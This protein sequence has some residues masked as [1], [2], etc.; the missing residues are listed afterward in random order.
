MAR[1]LNKSLDNY[2][3]HL[4][5]TMTGSTSTYD[6]YNR[7]ISRFI[8]FLI[9]NEVFDFNDVSKEL[10]MDYLTKLKSGIIGGQKLSNSSFSRNLS[11]LRSL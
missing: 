8:D 9:E 1:D 5:L 3:K 11:A 4:D 10:V 2:L 6:S 7:D